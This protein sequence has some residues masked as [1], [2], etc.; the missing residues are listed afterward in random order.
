MC[1]LTLDV[2]ET[3]V[4]APDE[5][6]YER[7]AI[8]QALRANPI[9][10][11]TRQPMRLG[12]LKLNRALRDAIT[13]WR[14]EQPMAF[15]PDLLEI[16]EE[17][18][19]G[20][21]AFGLV[22]A[23]NLTT[24]GKRLRVAV[25]TLQDVSGAET[26]ARFDAELKAHTTAQQGADGVCRLLG[27]CTKNHRL[28][29]VMKR[30]DGSLR[31]RLEAGPLE[32]NEV[33][34]IAHA[35]CCTLV[36][37]HDAGVVV[38]DI[39]PDNV[40]FDAHEQPV[41]ADFG[42]AEVVTRTTRIVPTSTKGTFNYMS[43]E[44]F[45]VE[46]HG[47]EVDVWAIGCLVVEMST[48]VMPFAG[49]QMQQIVRAVC[50]RRVVPDVPDHAPAADVVRRCFEFDRTDR[51]TAA[52]LA[53]ALKPSNQPSDS[54]ATANG[55]ASLLWG[56]ASDAVAL[57]ESLGTGFG[58]VLASLV[59]SSPVLLMLYVV[60]VTLV[61]HNS[62]WHRFG[63]FNEKAKAKPKAKAKVKASS[64]C[65]DCVSSYSHHLANQ[66]SCTLACVRAC[67]FV[68]VCVCVALRKE[69]TPQ[70]IL[71]A[72]QL[73]LTRSLTR[74][75]KLVSDQHMQS[76][77]TVDVPAKAP[78][79]KRKRG[80]DVD[81]DGEPKAKAW[82]IVETVSGAKAPKG[83]KAAQ[84]NAM[85]V[86]RSH[87]P[88]AQL[89]AMSVYRSCGPHAQLNAMSVYRSHGPHAQLNV[90]SVYRSHG[91]HV[92]LNVMSV[93]RSHGPHAQLNAMSVHRS[94]GLHVQLNAMSVYRSRG[95]HFWRV[96]NSFMHEK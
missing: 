96:H 50:D 81:D 64:A 76:C 3:P 23:G 73:I 70:C 46:G 2:M 91:S 26:R 18:V 41:I 54:G 62:V 22:V 38:R 60:V 44:S 95:P 88:H 61:T 86:Y 35:L 19:L 79:S 49:L 57:G 94:H 36:Q 39:K 10:P 56:N 43:P 16:T 59:I 17:E 15:D 80:D 33:Q 53:E 77:D 87:G 55:D 8:E 78:P 28:C 42:I 37:L 4:L 47:P 25:K 92:H 63:L 65:S 34:R 67:V 69:L 90:M 75:C 83:A 82:I 29:I 1:P 84:L 27:T 74:C 6:T 72:A 66:R 93:Y 14:A 51:P 11:I 68:C 13:E 58:V 40:L 85:S 30:Y 7:G 20:R 31:D 24:H 12:D 45:E 9:S 5:N 32:P 48:G 71:S 52:Q 89:N 21:G